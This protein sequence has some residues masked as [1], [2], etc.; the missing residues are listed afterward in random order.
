MAS[1][2]LE[3]F[4]DRRYPAACRLIRIYNRAVKKYFEYPVMSFDQKRLDPESIGN[5]FR[6]T[7]GGI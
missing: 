2:R 4:R 6:Q 1:Q 3:R 5:R 7:G